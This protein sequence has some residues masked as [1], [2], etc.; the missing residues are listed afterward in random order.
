MLALSR[1]FPPSL[2][3]RSRLVKGENAQKC[4]T[5][6]LAR[7]NTSAPRPWPRVAIDGEHDLHCTPRQLTTAQPLTCLPVPP[8]TRLRHPWRP[9]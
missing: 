5:P 1:A 7:S 9:R 2:P 6:V 4:C 8:Q 3:L